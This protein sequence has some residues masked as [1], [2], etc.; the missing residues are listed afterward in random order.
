MCFCIVL[1]NVLT[2]LQRLRLS[3]AKVVHKVLTVPRENTVVEFSAHKRAGISHND[4]SRA[5]FVLLVK[6]VVD[7]PSVSSHHIPELLLLYHSLVGYHRHDAADSCPCT[8]GW[9]F[10]KKEK[11]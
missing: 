4:A 5:G 10:E 8:L 7:F 3:I 2:D 9:D 1:L 6:R 11:E